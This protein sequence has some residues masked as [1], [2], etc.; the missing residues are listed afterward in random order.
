MRIVSLIENISNCE[1][2][3]SEHGLSLYIEYK[4]KRYIMDTGATGKFIDNANIKGIDLKNIDLVI[5]SH[6][7]YDHIGGLE[8]L[9]E[10][11]NNVKV[12]IEKGALQKFY[13]KTVMNENYIGERE[14]LFTDYKDRFIFIDSKYNIADGFD[15]MTCDTIDENFICKDRKRLC[16]LKNNSLVED[17]FSHELFAVIN[18]N[19]KII[20]LSSC[21]HIGII[22]IVMNVK[23][24]YSDKK[25]SYI[26]GGFHMRGLFGM[27]TLNCDESYVKE[28]ANKLD[29]LGVENIYTCH[30]TGTKAYSIFK[31]VFG[32][33][34]KYFV[35]GSELITDNL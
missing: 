28:V 26:I 27:D 5:I 33:R 31:E 13:S 15:V 6:N 23:N 12:V 29:E 2:Y 7:H 11:N 16:V 4:G 9:F 1:K 14:G 30:C 21:S 24:T 32:K 10:I 20:V 17:D 8:K 25:I 22:N 19:N 34:T 3:T 35:T 18:D